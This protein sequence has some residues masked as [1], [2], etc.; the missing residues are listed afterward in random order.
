MQ[1]LINVCCDLFPDFTAKIPQDEKV[2][3]VQISSD[4]FRKYIDQPASALV[5]KFTY[6]STNSPLFQALTRSV[7]ISRVQRALYDTRFT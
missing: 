1:V 5:S 3:C 4:L 6:S 7:D 2:R